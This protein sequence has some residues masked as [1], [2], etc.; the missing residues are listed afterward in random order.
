MTIEFAWV[1]TDFGLLFFDCA[2]DGSKMLT[3]SVV[4]VGGTP[5]QISPRS[6]AAAGRRR[7]R[8]IFGKNLHDFFDR[9]PIA[10]GSGHTQLFLNL[11][12]IADRFHLATIHTEDE[13]V[14]NRDDLEQPV[15][16]RWQ[17][18][19]KRRRRAKAPG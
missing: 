13:S 2:A 1:T 19:R 12:E 6:P 10:R 9:V 8:L 14:F 18:E 17:A 15:V 7:L 5:G 16:V 4:Q 3:Q 11:A